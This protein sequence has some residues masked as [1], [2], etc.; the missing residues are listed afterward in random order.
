MEGA[1]Q[2]GNEA[3]P[4]WFGAIVSILFFVLECQLVT[5][6]QLAGSYAGLDNRWLNI[7]ALS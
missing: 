2:N 6:L 1:H 5:T 4:L 7:A 3:M